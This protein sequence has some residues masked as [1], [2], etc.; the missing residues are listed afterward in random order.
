MMVILI[1]NYETRLLRLFFG[2]FRTI[3]FFKKS[4][5]TKEGSNC[6]IFINRKNEKKIKL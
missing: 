1:S 5:I 4:T 6:K 2:I 3:E